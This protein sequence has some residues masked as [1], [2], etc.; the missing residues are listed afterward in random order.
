[1]AHTHKVGYSK[2][3]YIKLFEQGAFADV[4]KMDYVDGRLMAPQQSGFALICQDAD[5]NLIFDKSKVVV[6]E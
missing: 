3:G 6:I 1:M 2:K 5:G 4:K